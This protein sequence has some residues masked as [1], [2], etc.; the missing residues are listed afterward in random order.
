MSL[1]E[2]RFD[3]N[4]ESGTSPVQI[5]ELYVRGKLFSWEKDISQLSLSQILRKYTFIKLIDRLAYNEDAMVLI[6]MDGN[7]K[8]GSDLII[9]MRKSQTMEDF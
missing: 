8:I 7:A 9:L 4:A 5:T 2:F 3:L 6:E 1:Y